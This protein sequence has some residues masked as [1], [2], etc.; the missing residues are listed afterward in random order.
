MTLTTAAPILAALGFVAFALTLAIAPA[1]SEPR[2]NAWMFPATL[3]V[4]FLGWTLYALANEGIIAIWQEISRSLWS[5]QI[6]IDLLLAAG[7]ALA[8]LVPEARRL[9]MRPLPWVI[10]TAATGC[11]G[12]L[13]MLARVLFLRAR[14]TP[15]HVP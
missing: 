13:G 15:A 12:L 11:I 1:R 7:I 9:G 4:A 5:N 8:F 14:A 3:C 6:F 10:A 2:A